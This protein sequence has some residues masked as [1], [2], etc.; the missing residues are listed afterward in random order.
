MPPGV[1]RA[2]SATPRRCWSRCCSSFSGWRIRTWP[3]RGFCLRLRPSCSSL[4]LECWR[5]CSKQLTGL[6]WRLALS[7]C[8]SLTWPGLCSTWP[9]CRKGRFHSEIHAE[10]IC[11]KTVQVLFVRTRCP[12]F[13]HGGCPG[14]GERL[15]PASTTDSGAGPPTHDGPAAHHV[16]AARRGWESELAQR[17]EL[18]RVQGEFGFEASR[19]AAVEERKESHDGEDVVEKAAAGDRG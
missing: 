13:A 8:F 15:A 18:R 10:S 6:W 1:A 9:T 14:D 2:T 11:A 5:I 12:G 3:G 4:S 17:R 19:P 7:R 16:V